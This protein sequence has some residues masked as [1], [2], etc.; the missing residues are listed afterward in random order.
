LTAF[1]PGCFTPG[2]RAPGTYLIGGGAGSRTSLDMVA[3]R[4]KFLTLLGIE[5]RLSSL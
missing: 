2:G 3:K 5:T 1:C 4:R